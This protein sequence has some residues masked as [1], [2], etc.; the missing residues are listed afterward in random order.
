MKRNLCGWSLLTLAALLS[1]SV[2]FSADPQIQFS[3]GQTKFL[4][5]GILFGVAVVLLAG[6]ATKTERNMLGRT[7]AIFGLF[8][9]IALLAFWL[10]NIQHDVLVVLPK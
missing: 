3:F 8:A 9:G 7:F 1:G 2:V 10:F 5:C 6:G 4:L